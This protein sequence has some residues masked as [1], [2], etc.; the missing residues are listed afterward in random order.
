MMMNCEQV[1]GVLMD[2][3]DQQLDE[4][5]GRAVRIHLDDCAQCRQ[6]EREL[7]ELMQAI[8]ET[9]LEQ[10]GSSIRKNFNRILQAELQGEELRPPRSSPRPAGKLLPLSWGR[11][12]RQIAAA[13]FLLVVGIAIGTRISMNKDGNSS[14]QLNS[15]QDEVKDIKQTLMFS[16]LKQESASERI[17]GVN[18][19]EEMPHPNPEVFG[20]LIATL[21]HD[22]NVNVR[23]ASLYSLSKFSDNAMVRDSLVSSLNRQSEPIIQIVLIHLLAERKEVKA[24][25]P[26]QDIL[27]NQNTFP[28]V[29]NIAREDLKKL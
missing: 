25:K 10:P 18:Y 15:L 29:K 12:A 23:L 26:I 7:R 17:R 2:Y 16:L 20:A 19:V 28:E 4:P 8:A 24:I 3:I 11:A 5:A 1:Q 14:G 9:P 27:T 22:K 6:V 13:C 21:N